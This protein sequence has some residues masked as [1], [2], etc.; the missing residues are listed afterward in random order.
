ML[1]PNVIS[2]QGGNRKTLVRPRGTPAVCLC[3]AIP[4]RQENRNNNSDTFRPLREVFPNNS[5]VHRVSEV[6]RRHTACYKSEPAT[7]RLVA[8]CLKH[9]ATAAVPH[10]TRNYVCRCRAWTQA[11]QTESLRLFLQSKL[12]N[13]ARCCYPF[14][15][16]LIP[17]SQGRVFNMLWRRDT[18]RT[19]LPK[20]R[21]KVGLLCPFLQSP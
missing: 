16:L 12:V 2:I 4:A 1:I 18:K 15:W 9:Y 3:S 21:P 10:T 19:A 20:G 11:L 17:P 6:L 5:L 7:F 8:Y 14:L 13:H